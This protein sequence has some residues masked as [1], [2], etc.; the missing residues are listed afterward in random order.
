MG[1]FYT[2]NIFCIQVRS[3]SIPPHVTPC[4]ISQRYRT[5]LMGNPVTLTGLFVCNCLRPA[6]SGEADRSKHSRISC[7]QSELVVWV[8]FY[9]GT[10]RLQLEHKGDSNHTFTAMA[11]IVPAF[12]FL[13][14]P[15]IGWLLD[16][17]GYGY[18]MGTINFLG[19]LACLFEAMP[20]L[21]FQVQPLLPLSL[22][23]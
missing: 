20:S 9:L 19:V 6:T 5:N 12:G 4:P 15:V 11:N 17:K 3:L 21:G 2:L 16:K 10:A 18:T 1:L 23:Q 7:F 8:Q 13:G 22:Q 14:I